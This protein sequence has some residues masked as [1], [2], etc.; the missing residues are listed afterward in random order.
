MLM[1]PASHQKGNLFPGGVVAVFF[2][3]P[4]VD[5][6][7]GSATDKDTNPNNAWLFPPGS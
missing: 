7:Q 2:R 4:G 5:C 3:V 1:A 6:S